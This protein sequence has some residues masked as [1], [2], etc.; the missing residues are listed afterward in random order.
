MAFLT[1][2]L[3][4]LWPYLAAGVMAFVGILGWRHGIRKGAKAEVEL[5]RRRETDKRTKEAR[6]AADKARKDVADDSDA[7]LDQRLRNRGL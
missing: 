1:A 2:I 6:H 7:D 5:E 4:D 3:G